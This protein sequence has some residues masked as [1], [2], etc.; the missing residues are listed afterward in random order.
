MKNPFFMYRSIRFDSLFVFL[1]DGTWRK[2][3]KLPYAG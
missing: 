2:E 1:P 3:N